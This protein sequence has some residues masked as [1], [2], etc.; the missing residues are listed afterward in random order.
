M[1]DQL[2]Q[3]LF[4]GKDHHLETLKR[5]SGT[6]ERHKQWGEDGWMVGSVQ[7][8][9]A[10]LLFYVCSLTHRPALSNEYFFKSS[11]EKKWL[12]FLPKLTN[13]DPTLTYF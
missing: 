4:A 11:S 13:P 12:W 7:Q 10:C 6:Q 2:K 3:V 9:I 1:E 8:T 5:K